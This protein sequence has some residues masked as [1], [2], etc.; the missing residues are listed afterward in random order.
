MMDPV[1]LLEGIVDVAV[2]NVTLLCEQD[3]VDVLVLDAVALHVMEKRARPA[4]KHELCIPRRNV[5]YVVRR[6]V[7][8]SVYKVVS[9][10][11][12]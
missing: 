7:K 6:C 3:L 9:A 11:V 1:L 4:F 8:Y 12:Q 5:A 10:Y 2:D